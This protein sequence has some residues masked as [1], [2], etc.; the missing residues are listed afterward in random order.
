MIFDGLDN[1]F[2]EINKFDKI[3]VDFYRQDCIPCQ[4]IS[5]YLLELD[6]NRNFMCV[7]IDI[8]EHEDIYK[9]Y[10]ITTVPSLVLIKNGKVVKKVMGFIPKNKIWS[11]Y[12]E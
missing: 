5:N 2:E 11:L 8:L 7:K 1:F 10:G 6:A 3:L 4:M 9:K 12:N